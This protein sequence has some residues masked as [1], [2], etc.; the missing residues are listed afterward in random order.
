MLLLVDPIELFESSPP[1][2]SPALLRLIQFYSPLKSL[3]ALAADADITLMH[4]FQL[5]GHMVYWAQAMVIYPICENNIY[6][7]APEAPTH[8]SSSLVERFNEKFPGENLLQ[9]KNF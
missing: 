1:D 4:V 2:S 3:Q 7:V 8:A 9:V 5:T 6:V